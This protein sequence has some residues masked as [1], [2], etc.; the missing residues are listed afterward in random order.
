MAFI[1]GARLQI[2]KAAGKHVRRHIAVVMPAVVPRIAAEYL[3]VL[4]AEKWKALAPLLLA[5]LA[6][7]NVDA[8]VA[9]VVASYVPREPERDQS[10]RVHQELAR[11]GIV[12]APGSRRKK[13]CQRQQEKTKGVTHS[14]P[15][16]PP[17]WS[18][19]EAHAWA[20]LIARR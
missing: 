3:F 8:R 2:E 18:M 16:Y 1:F 5:F 10:G 17:W 4:E 13:C 7:G 11:H 6:I 19:T 12:L 20:G 9:I 15:F 14:H